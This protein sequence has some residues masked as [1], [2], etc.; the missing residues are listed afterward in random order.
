MSAFSFKIHT[1]QGKARTGTIH[2][3][4]GAINTPAFIPVG[5][6]ATLKSL[7]PEQLDSTGAQA[8]LANAYHLYL[9]PGSEIIEKAGGLNKFMNWNKPILTDSGGF[10]VFSLG[11]QK[12]KLQSKD[13]GKLVKI[14]DDGV[15]FSSHIDGS[16][17]RF[18][19]ET[20]I[21]IQHKLGADIIMAFDECTPDDADL[22]YTKQ[23]LNR[24][25]VWAKR[26][27]EA[28]QKN[29]SYHGYRQFLFGIIQGAQ[30]RDLR[31]ESA[32]FI[33]SLDFDGIA[34][35][36]ESIGYNMKATAEIMDWVYPIIPEDKP[37]YTMGLGLNPLDLL[38][39]VEHGA[40]MFDCVAPTRLARHGMVYIFDPKNKHRLNITNASFT[41]DTKPLD[42]ECACFTCQR[43]SRSYLHHLF[44]AEEMSGMRLASVHNLHFMLK[45]MKEIRA[46]IAQ[47]TFSEFVQSWRQA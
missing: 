41:K 24:T 11:L 38:I 21:E 4:H 3:P 33:S 13:Q 20:S 43:Y 34:I 44:V 19:P 42:P 15:T 30:H 28:H 18:T 35:G 22:D 5:T 17:H 36:G 31:E 26:S 1:S 46:R 37:H 9:R 32:R 7:T 40:D 23:A 47:D 27:L 14:D 6:Q 2:T 12:E 8:V 25:H 10:Q 16:K 39:A 45:F 29:T